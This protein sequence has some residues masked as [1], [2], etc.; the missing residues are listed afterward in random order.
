MSSIVV[1]NALTLQ[2]LPR[3][4]QWPDVLTKALSADKV[5]NASCGDNI[6]GEK[7]QIS[8]TWDFPDTGVF[9]LNVDGSCKTASGN[10]GAGGGV[11][12]DCSGNW[13]KGFSV[14]LGIGQILEAELWGLAF[15][16]EMAL[17][18]GVSKITIEMDSALG[19]QL[20]QRTAAYRFHHIYTERRTILL[21][22]LQDGATIWIWAFASLIIPM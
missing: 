2:F 20:I 17:D 22:V 9:K 16:L 5:Q 10:I 18:K 1:S 6:A 15:G 12:R 7:L 11:L 3:Q 4:A 14:N 21:T 13:I 8:L 19:V